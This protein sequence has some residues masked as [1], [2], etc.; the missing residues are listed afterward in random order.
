MSRFR[1]QGWLNGKFP[2]LG[3]YA[4]LRIE[5]LPLLR[6]NYGVFGGLYGV[7]LLTESRN[8]PKHLNTGM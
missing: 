4:F 7:L 1:V 5:W 8:L 6:I 3:V 2:K